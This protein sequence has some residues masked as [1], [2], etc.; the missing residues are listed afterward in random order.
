MLEEKSR[1]ISTS[2]KSKPSSS[3]GSASIV[4]STGSIEIVTGFIFPVTDENAISVIFTVI[5][6]ESLRERVI[7]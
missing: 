1:Y 3:S 5:E 2:L 6:I 4:C 7:S